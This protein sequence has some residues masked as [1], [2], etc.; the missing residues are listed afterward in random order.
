MYVHIVAHFIRNKLLLL[1]YI[2]FR[3]NSSKFKFSIFLGLSHEQEH[4]ERIPGATLPV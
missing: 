3:F 4:L 1:L 2:Y